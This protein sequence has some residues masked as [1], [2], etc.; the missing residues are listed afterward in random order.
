[1]EERKRM[2]YIDLTPTWADVMPIY[3]AALEQGDAQ[4]KAAAKGELMR[5]AKWADAQMQG[6]MFMCE[7][8][9]KRFPTEQKQS[10][11]DE[12]MDGWE[13]CPDC[14]VALDAKEAQS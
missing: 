13:V 5:L 12:G 11:M 3:I 8:C 9:G 4:G 7:C 1:M 10:H 14:K 2:K 6:K